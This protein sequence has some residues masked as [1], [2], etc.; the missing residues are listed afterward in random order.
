MLTHWIPN[1]AV[2]IQAK[3]GGKRMRKLLPL[4]FAVTFALAVSGCGVSRSPTATPVLP[5][6]TPGFRLSSP[7]FASR[8]MIPGK[9]GRYGED[10]SPPLEWSDPPEGTQSFALIVETDLRPRLVIDLLDD[11][12]A[13]ETVGAV[14]GG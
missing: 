2:N 5:T 3:L 10:I 1:E 7:A 4:F 6:P 14:A 12:G 11:D 9:Y 8:E 13:V